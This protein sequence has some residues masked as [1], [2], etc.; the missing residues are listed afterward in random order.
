MFRRLLAILL[1]HPI[2]TAVAA[3]LYSDHFSAAF[4]ASVDAAMAQPDKEQRTKQLIDGIRRG[5]DKEVF[6]VMPMLFP[7]AI[8]NR[9]RDAGVCTAE[10]A[11]FRG[12]AEAY[13]SAT[14]AERIDFAEVHT[15]T[16][17]AATEGLIVCLHQFYENG[18]LRFPS[19]RSND[20][21]DQSHDASGT[22]L[23]VASRQ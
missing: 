8:L 13:L 10:I 19:K 16:I 1:L 21:L 22:R 14:E 5:T 4:R 9:A 6:F 17:R 20:S 2:S 3:D 11:A 18:E 15:S 7:T 23:V 12:T